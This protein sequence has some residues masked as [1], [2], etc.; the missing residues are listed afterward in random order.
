MAL[1]NFI[2]IYQSI[3]DKYDDEDNNGNDDASDD[4]DDDIV[5]NSDRINN[6]KN[7]R[8]QIAEDMWNDYN[9]YQLNRNN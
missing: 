4:D 1:H 9:N 3:P 7:W 8:N 2:R 5:D 6:L